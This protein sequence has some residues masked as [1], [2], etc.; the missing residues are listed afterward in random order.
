VASAWVAFA[1]LGWSAV[2]AGA[3]HVVA[4]GVGEGGADAF[5][6]VPGAEAGDEFRLL[7]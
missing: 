5:V 7:F 1:L 3:G 4:G 2:E 6:D